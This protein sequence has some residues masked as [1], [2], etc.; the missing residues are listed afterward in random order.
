MPAIFP[1]QRK[2]RC[3][4]QNRPQSIPTQHHVGRNLE[5]AVISFWKQHY[6]TPRALSTV[7][8]VRYVLAHLP[9]PFNYK[10]M[11]LFALLRHYPDLPKDPRTLLF[12]QRTT[13]SGAIAEVVRKACLTAE[14]R[15]KL[16]QLSVVLNIDSVSLH[17]WSRKH[18][19]PILTT[20]SELAK[21]RPFVVSIFWGVPKPI[22]VKALLQDTIRK[23]Q[24][25][26]DS[27]L[28]LQMYVCLFSCHAA[29]AANQLDRL[30]SKSENILVIT[31]L[32]G[33]DFRSN[34]N[35]RHHTGV[36]PFEW[37]PSDTISSFPLGYMHM[38]CLGLAK[39]LLKF[40][41]I[42]QV[43]CSYRLLQALGSEINRCI[44][45]VHSQTP[46]EFQHHCC[47][48]VDSGLWKVTEFRQFYSTQGP[49]YLHV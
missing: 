22:D 34:S 24:L 13:T 35:A 47:P 1:Q 25:V 45:S 38:V 9:V 36:S 23:L 12:T 49:L 20:A 39:K 30:S 6:Q 14:K 42:D 10:R 2:L 48:L 19:W 3:P 27:G 44:S 46:N 15:S 43:H 17:G 33:A 29:F 26:L 40:R 37:L 11:L 4:P 21:T 5:G 8:D 28:L 41:V 31:D 7:E 32:I 18:T 16:R